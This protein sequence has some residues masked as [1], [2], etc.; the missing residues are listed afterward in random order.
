MQYKGGILMWTP[1]RK[2][3]FFNVFKS[4]SLTS[5]SQ[6]DSACRVTSNSP[7]SSSCVI[8]NCVRRW[9]ICFPVVISVCFW[10]KMVPPLW[11]WFYQWYFAIASNE[12]LHCARCYIIFWNICRILSKRLFGRRGWNTG[13]PE[14]SW[15][16]FNSVMQTL[17]PF[18]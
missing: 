8:P 3:I 1:K 12:R 10:F 16:P 15:Y 14:V 7:A 6:F 9:R 13:S 18:V 2:Q 17:L 5:L 11:C 4:G